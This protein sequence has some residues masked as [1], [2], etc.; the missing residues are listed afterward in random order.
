MLSCFSH[1]WL[2]ATLW[3]FVLQASLSMGFFF[4]N[5]Y[6]L[7]SWRPITLQYCSGSCHTLTWI[8]LGYTCIPHP[9]PPS[10]LPL[11]PIPL[12]LPSAPSLSTCLMHLGWWSVSSGSNA[13][14]GCHFLLQ[15]ILT[16]G[17]N[18]C[19]ECL[20]HL[21]AGSLPLVLPGKPRFGTVLV[22]YSFLDNYGTLVQIL[23]LSLL[24]SFDMHEH[25][26]S[27]I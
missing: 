4:F 1:V 5:I 24:I 20:L 10:H 12:G 11:H 3:T 22:T 16:Q 19:L 26:F 25:I 17:T 7:I 14:V 27:L 21:Q 2:F 18:L 8:S 13:A 9:D 15:G 6:I 23:H